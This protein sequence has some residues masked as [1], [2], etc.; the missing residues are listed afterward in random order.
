MVGILFVCMGN[1]C[2]SPM[3]EGVFRSRFESTGLQA[4]VLIDSA[5]TTGYHAGDPP[6]PRG[7]RTAAQYGIDLSM[8]R[9]RKVV[10]E[11]F[12]LFD[13][14][15]AMDHDNLRNLKSQCPE[16]FQPRLGLF[17]DYADDLPLKELPDPYY[18]GEDGFVRCFNLV[19]RAAEGLKTALLARHFPDHDRS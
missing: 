2:R 14:I 15:L 3:A 13:Y 10:A 6:D 5:G 16:K 18:G 1:I 19:E 8:I 12:E 7:I 4:Q 9:S 17:L 11:D